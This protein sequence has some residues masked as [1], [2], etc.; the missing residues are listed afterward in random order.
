MSARYNEEYPFKLLA[1]HILHHAMWEQQ[2]H[3]NTKL[4]FWGSQAFRDLCDYTGVEAE[5]V[6]SR[7]VRKVAMATIVQQTEPPK[8]SC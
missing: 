8:L 2:R 5:M 3:P 1:A 7:A 6:R 4:E